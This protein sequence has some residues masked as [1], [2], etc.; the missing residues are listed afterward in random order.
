MSPQTVTG[1][2]TLCTLLSSTVMKQSH[3]AISNLKLLD[4]KTDQIARRHLEF[5]THYFSFVLLSSF[6]L[7]QIFTNCYK[8]L[9]SLKL[10]PRSYKA[11]SLPKISLAF[12]HRI[13]TSLSLMIS[14]FLSCSICWSKSLVSVMFLRQVKKSQ[15][16]KSENWRSRCVLLSII[17][18]RYL[19]IKNIRFHKLEF[20]TSNS[21]KKFWE[22]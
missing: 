21:C 10:Y 4:K 16:S 19:Q 2:S 9:S 8:I 17:Y 7:A 22:N 15:S 6:D 1:E 14:H 20:C 11:C 5:V 3:N 12:A 18:T 13:L